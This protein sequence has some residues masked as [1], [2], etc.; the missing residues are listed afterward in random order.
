MI[1]ILILICNLQTPVLGGKLNPKQETIEVKIKPTST[2]IYKKVPT[3]WIKI[4]KN[5]N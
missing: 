1:T 4:A 5:S 3:P 2:K